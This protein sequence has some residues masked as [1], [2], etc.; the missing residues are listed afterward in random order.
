MFFVLELYKKGLAIGSNFR[1]SSGT[2]R[3]S[4]DLGVV[5]IIRAI[6]NCTVIGIS[7][8]RR[9][10][11]PCVLRADF[12]VGDNCRRR[13]L[14]GLRPEAG[15]QND[16]RKQK[17]RVPRSTT[18]VSIRKASVGT[19]ESCYWF[20]SL[21]CIT[22]AATVLEAAIAS[23]GR[24]N[25]HILPFVPVTGFSDVWRRWSAP[26]VNPPRQRASSHGGIQRAADSRR[27]H[28]NASPSY[29]VRSW[30]QWDRIRFCLDGSQM[31]YITRPMRSMTIPGC[32]V[33][34]LKA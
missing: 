24:I 11:E 25:C 30:L 32:Q 22:T 1:I 12:S 4:S 10:R 20:G 8:H 7:N 34:L 26:Q 14:R 5:L 27:M 3:V 2:V 15:G 16:C 17:A 9:R 13:K 6:I 19:T 21:S 31:L 29:R 28:S 23:A 33:H 18:I